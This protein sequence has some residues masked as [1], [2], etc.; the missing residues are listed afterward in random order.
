VL[1]DSMNDLSGAGG[2]VMQSLHLSDAELADFQRLASENPKQGMVLF[3][4]TLKDRLDKVTQSEDNVHQ[5]T[6]S[7]MS[8]MDDAGKSIG[9]ALGG[10]ALDL[11]GIANP[12]TTRLED[13][14]ERNKQAGA[15]LNAAL[16]KVPNN[17]APDDGAI[18]K[19]LETMALDISKTHDQ[20]AAEQAQYVKKI[21]D[22]D[23]MGG[24]QRVHLTDQYGR[25]LHD[26]AVQSSDE[27]A[28]DLE[29]KARQAASA[30]G[31]A[32]KDEVEAE[33]G[34]LREGLNNTKLTADAK[35]DI[36]EQIA[37]LEI[38][39]VRASAAE[40]KKTTEEQW[41]DYSATM[42]N[43]IADAKGD[44]K[45]QM[46]LVTA[47][48]A[49]GKEMFPQ[50]LH[51]YEDAIQEENRLTQEH[52]ALMR[53]QLEQ[54]GRAAEALAQAQANLAKIGAKAGTGEFKPSLSLVFD[55]GQLTTEVNAQVAQLKAALDAQLKGV[56]AKVQLDLEAG[57]TAG[58]DETYAKATQDLLNY[59]NAVQ[60]L[61]QKAAQ[62]VQQSWEKITGPIG[63][64]MDQAFDAV[65]R[66]GRNTGVQL[67]HAAEGIVESWAK[68][69]LKVVTNWAADE[70]KKLVLTETGVAARS[71]AE[72]TG[73][74][75]QIAKTL[76]LTASGDAVKAASN[77]TQITGD[78][79]VAAAGAYA[80]TAAIP[81]VGPELAPGAAAE[82]YG[83]VM[84]FNVASAEGGMERTHAGP[85]IVHEDEMVLPA[86]LADAVRSMANN[87][88]NTP[89]AARM[90]PGGTS[91]TVNNSGDTS[92]TI[93]INQTN[94][95]RGG[96]GSGADVA[97]A[98][99]KGNSDLH[100]TLS[101]WYGGH[102]VSLPGR[103]TWR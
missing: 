78:A 45:Q 40:A 102:S 76:G 37:Q 89:R 93:N 22:S 65:V 7:L 39:D 101:A 61:N 69:G 86:H 103:R 44:Y 10:P 5:S 21:L 62:A 48:V 57:S 90:S 6:W 20:I 58:A 80:A 18:Q 83:A 36:H 92:H 49:H 11:G 75:A 25:L 73:L 35:K 72:E 81:V 15:D 27:T 41:Q 24:E 79:A 31:A 4:D 47:W 70:I 84:S 91:S 56:K 54:Q 19:T 51:A 2:K 3:L 96:S 95:V 82:A 94:N 87:G 33:L 55:P 97:N 68:S 52:T 88:L 13:T 50:H 99:S 77:A 74:L 23:R 30:A 32:R 14:I 12:A 60:Q 28:K 98:I 1:V 42:R 64:A 67:E 29:I 71:A 100:S 85:M 17:L 43:A 26:V 34:V 53:T 46:D 63:N 8:L 66:G 59:T 16:A 9:N 38:R